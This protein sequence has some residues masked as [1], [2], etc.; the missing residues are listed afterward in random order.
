MGL[1]GWRWWLVLVLILF[2]RDGGAQERPDVLFLVVDD[3]NDWINV[4]DSD[5]P[6]DTP[7]L[8]RLADR[9]TLFTH[10]YCASPACNP[11]RVATLTGLRPTSTGV[12]GNKSDWR[13]ALPDR[14]TI[15][16]KFIQHG[17]VVRGAGKIFHHHLD[18]AFHDPDSFHDF[19][20]DA[21]TT[22]PSNK[23]KSCR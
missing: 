19:S 11:S 2:G 14:Q 9:G 15:M 8:K 3:L 4:L 23:N 18:G 1:I 22:L 17:Y 5:A 20:T 7:N 13:F 12:Y 10:A 6:I 16:Q 21:K